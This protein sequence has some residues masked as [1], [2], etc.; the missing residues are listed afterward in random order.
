MRTELEGVSQRTLLISS[1]YLSKG[2]AARVVAFLVGHGIADPVG[3][4][5]L[6]VERD[7]LSRAASLYNQA[8][9]DP[10]VGE[11]RSPDAWLEEE[12]ASL[13]LEPILAELRAACT[14]VDV[15]PYEPAESL[16]Q[17]VLMA[18][19]AHQEELPKQVPW[20]N[21]SMSEPVLM[22]L[23]EV[24]RTVAD[25]EERLARGAKLF[26]ALRPAFATSQ[27]DIFCR[28]L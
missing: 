12:A 4:R 27:S 25:P 14:A 28:K 10:Y 11:T 8:V 19:G 17:R 5:A 23:L 21:T 6:L 26:Q 9:K 15:L 24:N 7:L 13:R 20:S 16:V 1:E 3:I 18:A 2:C 22:A